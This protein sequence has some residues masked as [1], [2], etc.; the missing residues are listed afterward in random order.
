MIGGLILAAG[1][2]RRFGGRKLLAELDGRPLISHAV[3][4]MLGVAAVGRCVVVLGAD[5]EE[6]REGASLGGVE[7]VVADDWEQ[8]ISASLRR[9]VAELADCELI[10]L[11]LGDQ[12]LITTEAIVA[13][14]E[15]VGPEPAARATYDGAPGHPVAI[16]AELF[17]AIAALEGDGGA[18]GLLEDAGV[19]GFEAGHLCRP[20]DVDTTEDLETI[21][22]RLEAGAN[23]R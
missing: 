1:G 12:P 7:A 18:Q 2:A 11:T 14:L 19:R 20:D 5:A 16:R 8:G 23:R 15:M 22:D 17:E 10:L 13:T 21:R 3:E 4:A 9:G 6:I